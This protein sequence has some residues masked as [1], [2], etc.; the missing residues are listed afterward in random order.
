MPFPT[1]K[2][3]F[4]ENLITEPLQLASGEFLQK[5]AKSPDFRFLVR[6]KK[7]LKNP[8]AFGGQMV[9]KQ[10]RNFY[11]NSRSQIPLETLL[12]TQAW[13]KLHTSRNIFFAIGNPVCFIGNQRSRIIQNRLYFTGFTHCTRGTEEAKNENS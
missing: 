5:G 2:V 8:A 10:G 13:N 4:T 11:K 3:T 6:K 1:R 7:L 9:A 12:C